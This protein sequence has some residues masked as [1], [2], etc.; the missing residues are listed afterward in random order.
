MEY[1]VVPIAEEHIEAFHAALDVVAREKK[2]L[3]FLKAPPLRETRKF[4]LGNIRAGNPQFVALHD[5]QLIGWCDV[6]RSARDTSRHSG[7]L[8]VAL[9]PGY[10]GKGIGRRLM[11]TVID[12]AWENEFTRIE[13]SVREDNAAAIALYAQ[14]GF[15]SEGL[16]RN[17]FR[18]DGEYE[19]VAMMALLK[20]HAA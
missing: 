9:V 8:G 13:L 11:K 12:A 10:R 19:N 20:E 1:P 14:L 18:V 4:V 15:Q 3:A 5:G 6:V 7:V 17:A 2:Y 16:R